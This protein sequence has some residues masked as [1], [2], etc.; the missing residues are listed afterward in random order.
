MGDGRA[1]IIAA[2]GTGGGSNVRVIDIAGGAEVASFDAYGPGFAGGV[3]V[4]VGDVNGDGVADIVT[5][6]GAGGGPHVRAIHTEGGLIE[7]ASFFAYDPAFAGGVFVAVG[8]VTGDGVADIVTGAGA[9]GGPHVRAFSLASD[10]A[11]F[12]P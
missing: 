12:V 5:G 2:A 9:G 4:A 7:I 6:A 1:D 8:D 11:R 10:G 3:F